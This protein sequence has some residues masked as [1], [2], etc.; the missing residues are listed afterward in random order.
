M[1][2][3]PEVVMFRNVLGKRLSEFLRND[4]GRNLSVDIPLRSVTWLKENSPEDDLH[5]WI[6]QLARRISGMR[7]AENAILVNAHVPGGHHH[8]HTDSVKLRADY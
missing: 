4:T 5:R 3:K 7:A 8:V 6:L 2:P 1:H